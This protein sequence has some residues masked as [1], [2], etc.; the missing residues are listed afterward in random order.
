MPSETDKISPLDVNEKITQSLLYHNL[1]IV[2]IKKYLLILLTIQW[3][4]C[5]FILGVGSYSVFIRN[6][7][8]IS[9]GI[10]SLIPILFLAIYY[11]FGLVVTYQEHQIGLLIFTSIGVIIFI[12]ICIWFGYIMLVITA[13]TVGFGVTNQAYAVLAVFGIL[14]VVV[15]F[16]MVTSLKFSYNLAKLISTNQYST[17]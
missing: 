3:L 2:P 12:A 10:Q 9:S 14:F 6:A 17:V 7:V 4:T 5:I 16:F 13:L 11:V 15:I 1:K 8:D